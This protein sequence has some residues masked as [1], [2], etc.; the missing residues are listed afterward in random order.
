VKFLIVEDEILIQKSIK[1]MLELQ[2][3]EVDATVSGTQ[4]LDF[5]RL[6]KYDRVICDLMLKDITGFEVLEECKLLFSPDI[7]KDLFIIITAY[8]SDQILNLATQYG[9]SVIK[10]PFADFKST[11]DFFIYNRE[12]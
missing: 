6:K 5:L 3:H 2:G 4:A 8:S 11:I 1:K 9:C 7:I 12:L 10:K